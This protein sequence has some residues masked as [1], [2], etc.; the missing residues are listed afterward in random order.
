MRWDSFFQ[1]LED[2]LAAEWAA[3]RAALDSEAERVRIARLELRQRVGALRAA[4]GRIRLELI[5]E[6]SHEAEIDAVGAD[7]IA[8]RVGELG[9][10][11]APLAAIASIAVHERDLL[12]SARGEGTGADRLAERIT[13]GFALR[14]LARRRVPVTIGV[15]SGRVLTGTLDRVAHDHA[16][17]ALH[18]PGT[19]RRAGEV[20]GFRMVPLASIAW[21][22]VDAHA[23]TALA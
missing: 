10:L 1:D 6:S 18:E 19:P 17:V 13:F 12:R 11:M 16:D 2:Q 9:I 23:G 14:D 21:A 20:S 5:D 7:W 22:R 4:E 3:E 8:A 15:A